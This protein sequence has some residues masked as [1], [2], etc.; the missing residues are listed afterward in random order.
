MKQKDEGL[1]AR[2]QIPPLCS[3]SRNLPSFLTMTSGN[4]QLPF[5]V[6]QQLFCFISFPRWGRAQNQAA[7]NAL[8]DARKPSRRCQKS[9]STAW[10]GLEVCQAWG[11]FGGKEATHKPQG[12]EAFRDLPL[13]LHKILESHAANSQPCRCLKLF[14]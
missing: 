12:R 11:H 14:S 6:K 3:L 2:I 4:Y 1:P 9:R 5:T 10:L 7:C 13:A 8:E